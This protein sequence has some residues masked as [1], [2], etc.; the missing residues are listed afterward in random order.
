MRGATM[1]RLCKFAFMTSRFHVGLQQGTAVSG[2][3]FQ[4]IPTET[5]VGAAIEKLLLPKLQLLVNKPLETDSDSSS[6]TKHF[7]AN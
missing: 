6:F 7:E 2:S 1:G 5:T 3:D 4:K